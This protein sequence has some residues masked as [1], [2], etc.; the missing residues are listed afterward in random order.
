MDGGG[1]VLP[2]AARRADQ[3]DARPARG[4]QFRLTPSQE[5]GGPAADQ[6]IQPNPSSG[7]PTKPA[8]AVVQGHRVGVLEI[9]SSIG[10]AR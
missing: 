6:S 2:T 9:E 4:R 7:L 3:Q 8:N 10:P 5:H 1:Q